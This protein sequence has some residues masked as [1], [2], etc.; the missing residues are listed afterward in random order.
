MKTSIQ[1]MRENG[2][3]Q[4][5]RKVQR[6]ESVEKLA[7]HLQG[8]ERRERVMTEGSDGENTGVE[9]NRITRLS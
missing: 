1:Q 9:E 6:L 8:E 4:K 5:R 3:G 2:K 7:E